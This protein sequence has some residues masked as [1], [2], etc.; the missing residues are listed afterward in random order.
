MGAP[1]PKDSAKIAP[2]PTEV[3]N[4]HFET[5]LIFF[6]ILLILMSFGNFWPNRQTS[7][8]IAPFLTKMYV[9][10]NRIFIFLVDFFC[11]L[12]KFG[13]TNKIRAQIK[14]R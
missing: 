13:P 7:S 3:E 12:E 9:E 10:K 4:W 11:R 5:A 8:E 2:F 14:V 6:Q 1:S